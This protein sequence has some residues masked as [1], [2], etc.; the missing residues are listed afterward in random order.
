[1]FK[2]VLFLMMFL[3]FVETS[4]S[5]QTD[6]FCQIEQTYVNPTIPHIGSFKTLVVL[7]KFS[8]DNFD[9]SP[10]TNLWPHTLNSMPDW[11]SNI[12]SSTVQTSYPNPSISGYYKLM[13]N[14]LFNVFGD[15]VYYQ[16]EHNQDYY[17]I[18]SGKHIGYLTEEILTAINQAP[19]N[20]NFADYDNDGDGFVDMIQICFR[21]ANISALDGSTYQGIAGLT[22]NRE[23][24]G[25]GTTLS[26]DGKLIKAS[27]WGSGTFQSGVTDLHGGLPVILHEFGHY[28]FGS[29]LNGYTHL[30]GVHH[31]G[32]MDGDG[33]S[34]LMNAYERDILGWIGPIDIEAE[35][36]NI[37][38]TD[39]FANGN[40]FK[41]KIPGSNPV[42]YYYL[43]KRQGS[44]Y[45]ENSWKSYN[46]GPLMS[47]GTGLL[48]SK[49]L[50]PQLFGKPL[51]IECADGRWDWKRSGYT[52][53]YPF[54][55][56]KS[57]R[58]INGYDEL[59]LFK[60]QTTNGEQSHPN[61]LG[62]SGDFFKIGYNQLFSPA[63]NPA[64]N[65]V[66]FEIVDNINETMHVNVY[67]SNSL[68][69]APSK[70]QNLKAVWDSGHPKI[71]WEA[72]LETDMSSYKIYYM[73]E[74][75]TGWGQIATVPH[76]QN[77]SSYSWTDY[78]VVQGTKWDSKNYIHY[79]VAAVDNTAKESICSDESKVYGHPTLLWKTANG[80]DN[81]TEVTEFGL[82]QNYPNPFNPSTEISYQI[83]AKGFVTLKVYDMLGNEVSTLVNEWQ[84]SG[85]YNAQFTTNGRRFASG[86][87]FYTL[88]AGKFTNTKKLI[89]LK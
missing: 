1:M 6:E 84:E 7:C 4:L 8:D 67:Y 79:K 15:V 52:L 24:F 72:N 76:V 57:N 66:T 41:I 14:G 58:T 32:L 39:A 22:G 89:L 35:T 26:F 82:Q 12:I 5:Q 23:T 64:S 46:E 34:S 60:V 56:I 17:S 3:S 55:K 61:S 49:T 43:E 78:S 50:N 53:V 44:N 18:A 65:T 19:Y 29:S 27:K 48:I 38:L 31:F 47:P 80:K 33:G 25:S 88:T 2:K 10:Y 36:L 86:M 51:D 9:L 62:E 28:L 69:T 70:P 21:F 13:S 54:E 42:Q 68:Q 75:E 71:T 59:N 63:S 11:G 85:S 77:V 87:Y 30:Y 74:G 45:Y 73:V 83:P 40:I 16:P 20:I 81:Q 37:S